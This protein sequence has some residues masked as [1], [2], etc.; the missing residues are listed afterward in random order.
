VGRAVPPVAAAA[1]GAMLRT[2][3]GDG[4]DAEREGRERV[5]TGRR[6]RE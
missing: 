4:G 2:R 6:A 3:E 5:V 1:D